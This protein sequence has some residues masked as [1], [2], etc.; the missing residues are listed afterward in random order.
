MHF[1]IIHSNT[2]KASITDTPSPSEKDQVS[3][4]DQ[5]KEETARQTVEEKPIGGDVF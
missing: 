1:Y 3:P 4:G 5:S 2:L